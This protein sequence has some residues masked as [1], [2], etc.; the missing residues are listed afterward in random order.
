MAPE[1][2]LSANILFRQHAFGMLPEAANALRRTRSAQ[3]SDPLIN[4]MLRGHREGFVCANCGI[5]LADAI[6]AHVWVTLQGVPEMAVCCNLNPN[7]AHVQAQG[8]ISSGQAVLFDA[9]KVVDGTDAEK[10]CAESTA[11]ALAIRSGGVFGV[12]G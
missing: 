2:K 8:L 10:Q 1:R 11:A 12:I 7:S 9:L 4:A 3:E 5:A 6:R